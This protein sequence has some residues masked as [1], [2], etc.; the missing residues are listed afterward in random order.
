MIISRTPFR[1]SF[2]GGGSDLPSFY[3]KNGGCVLS[4]GID[5]Y[6][7]ISIH[8]SFDSEST[9][10]KYST[11]E[12]VDNVDEIKHKYFK[13]LINKFKIN[14]IEI[15]STAD[16]PAG[17]GLG[18]SSS[19]TVGVLHAL[20]AYIG[21]YVSKERLADEAC[22]LEIQDLG[23]PIGKQDQY[24]AA[25]G[26]LNFYT[27]NKDGTVYVDPVV[28]N[29]VK[30]KELQ[31][32]LIMFY[33]G[34]E[35]SASEIL[36]EQGRSVTEGKIEEN[37]KK[38]CSLAKDLRH[39]LTEGNVDAM[40]EILDEGWILKRSLSSGITNPTI[41]EYYEIGMKNGAIGGKLLGAGG[42]GFLLFYVRSKDR[43][44]L[45][46]AIGLQE[47]PIRFDGQGTTIIYIGN[48]TKL[49]R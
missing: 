14:G 13:A 19:F 46:N 40:G 16:V 29:H 21:K 38:M 4:T 35:H 33:I 7:Y 36:K 17:T 26:G 43:Q 8:P 12:I 32:N 37:Q 10:L 27:F 25:F 44:H 39:E 42:C 11:T 18:S 31:E 47:L 28:M 22:E 41:D 9:A 20:Y 45:K 1:I 6:M 30:Y 3:K 15:T 24:A 5:K 2:A 49:C 23:E 48:K 34:G